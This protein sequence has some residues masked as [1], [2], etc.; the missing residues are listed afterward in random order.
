MMDSLNV[1]A[2]Q[3]LLVASQAMNVEAKVFDP[4]HFDRRA[5]Q[6]RQKNGSFCLAHTFLFVSD[7]EY[8][9]ALTFGSTLTI[10]C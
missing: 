6:V 2:W 10:V 3:V 9:L 8:M 1:C 7:A 4:F 5:V